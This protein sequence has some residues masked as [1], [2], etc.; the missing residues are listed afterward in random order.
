M[1]AEPSKV[2]A[3]ILV[4]HGADDPFVPPEEVNAF[5]K[6]MKNAK[7]DWE[8]VAYGNAVHSF[9]NRAAGNDNSKGAAFHEQADRRSFLAMKNFFDEVF[10]K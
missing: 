7:A 9:T 8:L 10:K 5:E 6:E 3:K 1:P 4:L 2:R